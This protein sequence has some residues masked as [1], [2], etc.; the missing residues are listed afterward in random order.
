M[1]ADT[2]LILSYIAFIWLVI[3]HTLEEIA[4]EIIG[5]Q[6]GPIHLTRNRYLLAASAISTINLGTLALLVLG[7]APGY[8]LGLFTT[9][10]IGIFQGIVHTIGYLR[11]N[12]QARRMGAGFY[13]SV[14]L[15]AVGL[16]VLIQ[17]VQAIRSF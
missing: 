6:V 2:T 14:P 10:V 16:I 5:L 15:A 11:E 8:Y 4:C 3:L 7:L 9:S 13:S 17:L 1:P 12:R